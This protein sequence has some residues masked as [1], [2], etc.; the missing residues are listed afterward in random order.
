MFK[1]IGLSGKAGSGKDHIASRIITP[2]YGYVPFSLAWHIKTSLIGKNACTYEEAF[3]TKPPRVRHLLQQEGTESGRDIYGKDIWLDTAFAWMQLVYEQWGIARFV[4]P[5]VR[6]PNEVEYIKRKGGKVLR[7]IA[8]NRVAGS[9]LSMEARMHRSETA[10]DDYPPDNY[11]G[12][13]DNDIGSED[14]LTDRVYHTLKTL[15][16]L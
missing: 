4:V 14:T 10:L 5:D 6:F 11:D 16:L 9:P 13:L 3:I 15:D 2:H 1:V 7:I 12:L 8:P